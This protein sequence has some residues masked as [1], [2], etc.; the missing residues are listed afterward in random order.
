MRVAVVGSGIAGMGAAM[1]LKDTHDVS[2]FEASHRFGGHANTVDA[3][4][5]D[6]KVPVDT[7]FIVYNYRNYPNLTGLFEHLG[8]PT[9]WSDMS[10]GISVRGGRVE[11]ACD[12]FDQLFAQRRNLLNPAHVTGLMQILRFNREAPA[13][14]AK[15]QLDGLS[16]GDWLTQERY[17]RWFRDCFVLPFGGAIWSTPTRDMLDFP[18]K[19]FVSFFRN[20]DLMNGMAPMQRWRTVDGG[21]REYVRRVIAALGT[22]ARSGAEV[23]EVVRRG[24][25]QLRFRDGS[26]AVF[27]AVVLA[28]H[29]PQAR[30]LLSDRDVTEENLLSRFRTS[31]NRAVLHSDERLMPRR[32]KVWSS[33]NFLS[34]GGAADL[35]RPAPVTYWMNRLQGI[36]ERYPL[37]VSLNPAVEIAQ[38]R[39]HGSFEYAHPVFDRD[40]FAAQ[41]EIA[42]IQGNGGVWYAGAWLGYGFHEDGLRSGLQV[43][44]ALGATPAWAR[45]MPE[46][47][48]VLLSEAAE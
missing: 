32:R 28:C 42:G 23:V 40:S 8:V 13:Q 10:F 47:A 48:R 4:F 9:K 35:D 16:L 11:Y 14:L 36:D 2:L 20:H 30:L 5:G 31:P 22:R 24:A 33:W 25:P 29:G 17:S 27:D 6:V 3:A 41:A 1:A 43:A 21:S 45:D 46:P 12:N 7:G 15:G 18:A 37:F 44:A 34:D 19:N 26:E 38:E 39:V